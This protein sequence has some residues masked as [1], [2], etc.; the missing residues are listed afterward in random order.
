MVLT[1]FFSNLDILGIA[2]IFC[3]IV[4]FTSDHQDFADLAVYLRS[5]AMSSG[6]SIMTYRPRPL[7]R[8]PTEVILLHPSRIQLQQKFKHLR[9]SNQGPLGLESSVVTARLELLPIDISSS[10]TK[11]ACQSKNPLRRNCYGRK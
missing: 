5:D 7:F 4:C 8:V 3:L 10:Q 11:H 1:S 9:E 2:Y 6:V